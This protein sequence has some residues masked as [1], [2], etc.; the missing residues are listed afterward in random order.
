MGR[1]KKNGARQASLKVKDRVLGSR[2][3]APNFNYAEMSQQIRVQKYMKLIEMLCISRF[4]WRNLP[5]GIDMRYLEMTLLENGVA[6]FFP[7]KQWHR[8]VVT[9][10]N[11][12]NTNNYNNPTTFYPI[13]TGYHYKQLGSK[14]C[15]P[16]WDNPLR[17]TL[18][19]VMGDYAMR[20][21][22]ADRALDVNLDNISIPLIIACNETQ[23]LTV[24]NIMKAREN[25]APY[26]YTYD[27]ADINSMFQ[28]F[29]NATPFIADKV[30]NVKTQVWN[31]LVN[32]LGIQNSTTE[33]KE[34]LITDEV[35]AGNEKT[36]VFRASFL[37]C[38]QQACDTIN[39][40]WLRRAGMPEL[41]VD[42]SDY[43]SG[44][45]LST[46]GDTE[47]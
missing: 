8:F 28:T 25:G 45:I 38:R 39:D 13:A 4:T 15:V 37:Q 2:W 6:L 12:G 40:L 14:E 16:I 18:L 29:P 22:I 1:R 42:W 31:E 5:Q 30:L 36:N 17:C 41:S 44:G 35:A 7:D 9:S 11:Y 34:R 47:E 20:L 10:G 19:D 3:S 24:E 26:V 23:K 46:D 27:S 21:A 32:F 33:K 43:L